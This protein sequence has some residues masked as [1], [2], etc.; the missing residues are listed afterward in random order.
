MLGWQESGAIARVSAHQANILVKPAAEHNIDQLGTAAD[1]QQR[2]LLFDSTLNP[3]H[4]KLVAFGIKSDLGIQVAT[5]VLRADGVVPADGERGRRLAEWL[6]PLAALFPATGP[7]CL[8]FQVVPIELDDELSQRVGVNNPFRRGFG[9]Q[10]SPSVDCTTSAVWSSE[11][12]ENSSS[13]P[14]MRTVPSSLAVC[15][16]KSYS[17]L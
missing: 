3:A 9:R 15:G 7:T 6:K 1:S 12:P 5:V 2:D 10:L 11:I 4:F 14:T 13:N 8:A 16:G 17:L